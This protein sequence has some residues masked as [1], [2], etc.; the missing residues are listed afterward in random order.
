MSVESDI[1]EENTKT[2]LM[3]SA[4]THYTEKLRTI[5]VHP[6]LSPY[7]TD[8]LKQDLLNEM[9]FAEKVIITMKKEGYFFNS[10]YGKKPALDFEKE[11][12]VIISALESYLNDLQESKKTVVQKLGST[13][14]LEKLDNEVKFCSEFLVNISKTYLKKT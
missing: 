8:Y 14:N 3:L 5:M 12:K 9:M 11:R 1:S 6:E 4:L 13:P 2:E 7:K 10:S